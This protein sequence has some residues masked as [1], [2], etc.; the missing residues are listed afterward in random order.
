[1]RFILLNAVFSIKAL[2]ALLDIVDATGVLEDKQNK[3]RFVP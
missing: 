2:F 3:R 1:M